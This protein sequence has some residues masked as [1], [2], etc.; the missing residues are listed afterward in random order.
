MYDNHHR[1][2]ST[3]R[4]RRR[5][6]DFAA[7]FGAVLIL[8]MVATALGWQYWHADRIYAG[9][10]VAGVPVGGLTRVEAVDRLNRTLVRQPLPPL[11]ISYDDRQWPVA[12]GQAK[13]TVDVLAAVNQAYMVG[14]RGGTVTQLAEQSWAALG[15]VD[16]Q[17]ALNLDVPQLRYALSQIAADVRTPARPGARVNDIQIAAQPGVDVDVEQ[18]LAALMTALE[19]ND[20]ATVVAAP[21]NVRY[22]EPPLDTVSL[23][24][25]VPQPEIGLLLDP[26]ILRDGRYGYVF[27]IDPA[28]LEE[29]LFSRQPLRLDEDRVRAV[30]KTWASQINIE[31]AD[32][33]LRFDIGSGAVQ[34]VQESRMGRELDIE[35]TLASIREAVQGG[36]MAGALLIRD[37]PPAVDSGNVA[38]MGIRELV[39]SATTYFAGSS[40]ARVRNIEVAADKFDGVVVPPNG[41]FS[42]NTIVEDVTSANGFEDSL[43]IWGD[44]T[45][46]GVGGGV[47]QVST[48]V[49]RAAYE[50]GLPILERYNHGYAVSWYGE[51]GLDATIYTPTVDFRFRNDT[52]A[53]L[54]IE[55]VVN[56]AG[57]TITFNFYGTKPDR[58]V[59][60]SDP[61]IRDVVEP[62]APIYRI[63]ES[64][65]AGEKK[66][67]DWEQKGM[68][69]TVRRTI[70]ENG[71]TRTETLTSKYQP[72]QAVYLVGPG[73]DIPVTPTPVPSS[74]AV[75]DAAEDAALPTP[76]P[77][78]T[79]ISP[80]EPVGGE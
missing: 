18:T 67:V 60:I 24:Q 70:V 32:A 10:T 1:R 37:L 66:Q 33:R 74:D 75:E 16:L 76:T 36:S 72:W 59:A 61:E 25:D 77:T 52:G 20:D 27:A 17:P 11:L 63:D 43:I 62:K 48:T 38:Q 28:G 3:Q 12:A 51:P 46:V 65:A 68:T 73:T 79:P 47:C 2:T 4:I 23:A 54:L 30:L 57:G 19:T 9:V 40:P 53:Y 44:R 15:L 71:E 5:P 58:V 64:L 56:S 31:P 50:A 41:V 42:F 21:L 13:A 69:A 49:F 45:A 7:L 22:L 26:L 6:A 29:M 39:A 55:P 78:A 35:G 8:L 34:V 14:R 80:T